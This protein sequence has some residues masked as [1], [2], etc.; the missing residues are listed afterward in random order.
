VKRR[1]GSGTNR[2]TDFPVWDVD[3]LDGLNLPA[4][5]FGG[6]GDGLPDGIGSFLEDRHIVVVTDN[7]DPGRAHAEKKAAAAHDAGAASI[8]IIHH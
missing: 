7:D 6:V 2:D 1:P 5:T 4:F 3:S 8:K